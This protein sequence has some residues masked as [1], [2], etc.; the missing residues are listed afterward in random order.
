MTQERYEDFLGYLPKWAIDS[1]QASFLEAV[2]APG[3]PKKVLIDERLGKVEI[4]NVGR[5]WPASAPNLA[6]LQ[7]GMF[8]L[9]EL[10]KLDPTSKK[11]VSQ[12]LGWAVQ[13]VIRV[14]TVQESDVTN[15]HF[16][17]KDD[18]GN[19]EYGFSVPH[20]APAG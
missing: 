8:R 14:T 15:V 5:G 11:D 6:F 17:T 18:Y 20:K 3:E 7:N 1:R 10:G 16:W 13:R 19:Y 2:G 4:A 9:I 12:F